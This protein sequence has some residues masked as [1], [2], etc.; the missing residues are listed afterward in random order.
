MDNNTQ[1]LY[2]DKVFNL[3]IEDFSSN[4]SHIPAYYFHNILVAL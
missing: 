3:A 2:R 4:T 1:I